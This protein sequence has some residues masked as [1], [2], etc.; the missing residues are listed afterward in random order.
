MP[1]PQQDQPQILSQQ[2]TYPP[3]PGPPDHGSP[4]GG[5][6]SVGSP[7]SATSMNRPFQYAPHHVQ[8]PQT[9]NWI[10]PPPSVY[11][12]LNPNLHPDLAFN[13][14]DDRMGVDFLIENNHGRRSNGPMNGLPQSP[15]TPSTNEQGHWSAIPRRIAATCPL[16]AIL[17][18]AVAERARARAAGTPHAEVV[19]PMYPNW[20][21]LLNKHT[22]TPNHPVSKLIIDI[23]RTFPDLHKLPEQ[24]AVIYIMFLITRWE[25]EPTKENYD[26]LPEWVRPLPSQLFT[27]HP[28]WLDYLPWYVSLF[29]LYY[30]P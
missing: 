18:D 22:S 23:C 3:P 15:Q 21:H 1:Y 4:H 20:N 29:L 13:Q 10:P 19:G 25:V 28:C 14:N 6:H 12:H 16:D 30:A 27:S 17:L 5:A 7:M 24:V 26:R 8:Q 11:Q 9:K 2:D